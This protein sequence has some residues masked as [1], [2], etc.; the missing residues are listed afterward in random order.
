MPLNLPKLEKKVLSFWKRENIFEKSV[1]KRKGKPDF[2]FYEGPPTANAP[3]GLHHVLA[4]VFKDIIC[5]FQTMKG[6]R[7][8]RKAGWDTHGLPVE[9]QIEKKLGFKNKRDI[10]SFGVSKFNRLCKKSV[11]SYKKTWEKLTE[12]IGYWLD[13]KNPYITYD[14]NYIETLWWILKWAF[15]KKLLYE[16]YKVVP[17][18]PRCGTPLSSHE[19]AQGYKRVKEPAVYLK[20][21]VVTPGFEKTFL[22]V[23]TTT[24]WTL[25][26]NVAIALNPQFTYLLFENS[27]G[28]KLIF[29]KERLKAL[30][31]EGKVIK[32]FQG[33][34]LTGL[35]YQ[36]FYPPGQF[37]ENMFLTRGADFVSL[38][39]GTGLVHIAPAFGQEDMELIKKENEELEKLGKK[40]I[41]ILI[42]VEPDGKFSLNVK[43]WA[44][45]FF[46]KADPLIIN[47]LKERG[48]LF[49][50]EM[51]EHEYPFCWRCHTPLMYYARKSWFLKMR[52]LQKELVRNNE[53]IN[54]VPSYLK[55]GRFGEWI[56]GVK[57]W[58]LSRERY[59]GT[60]LP[61]WVCKSCGYKKAIGSK[62]EL[63]KGQKS[64]NQYWVLRHGYSQRQLTNVSDC[65]PEK[66]KMHLTEKGKRTVSRVAKKLKK[67][68]I[69]IIF[70]SDLLRAK[71]TA[72]II[73]RETGAKIVYDKRLR[74]Y[75]VGIFNGKSTI[76][77]WRWLEKQK[78]FLKTKLPEGESL[79]DIRRRTYKL[80]LHLEKKYQGK[81]ILLVSHE[82]PITVLEETLKGVPLY[83]LLKERRANR[84][85][86]IKPGQLRKIEFK[87]LPFNR[88]M[89]LDFHKPLIDKVKFVCPKCGGVMERV[90]EVID[91]WFDSGAMPF[92]QYHWPFESRRRKK[93]KLMPPKLFPADYISEAIDQTRGWFYTLLAVSTLLGFGPS[94]KNVLSLG[95]ILD[96]KGEKMS[97]SKGNIVDPWEMIGKYGVDS[98]R[99]YFY[100]M[101]S[102][103]EPKLF[104][105]KGVFDVL[106]RFISIFWN[107]SLFF[108]T[109]GLKLHS[110]KLGRK[111]I[112]ILDKWILS[113]MEGLIKEVG[114]DLQKYDITSAARKIENFTISDL[115][116][117]YIRRSR[118][119]FQSPK[120]RKDL[121]IASRVLSFVLL[122]L[123]KISAPFIPFLSETIYQKLTGNAF[124]KEKSVHLEN[125]P[126]YEKRLVDKK[127]EKE[128]E[129]V[130]EIVS[131]ALRKRAEAKI[132]VRQPL[133]SLTIKDNVL[134]QKKELLE[135]IKGEVN[136]KEII[137][138]KKF[139]LDTRITPQLKEEG[140]LREVLRAIQLMRK[141]KK[142]KPNHKI[143]LFIASSPNLSQFLEKNKDFLLKETIARELY[144]IQEAN[145]P[146]FRKEL[147]IDGEK[148]YLALKKN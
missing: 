96:E 39:E 32:E 47:D 68:G 121:E 132:K 113:K 18:C 21:P 59:W 118:R 144:F 50:E 7:V 31:L 140:I 5:R 42:P 81:K 105:E 53:K 49:K 67:E 24:P 44:G 11:W 36:P 138:G 19:V 88:N 48:L 91:C 63:L 55:E 57:D 10:E 20:F 35:R 41:P 143:N 133:P 103:A 114:D 38:E 69:D 130:R 99:W 15:E 135:L 2:V 76:S 56:R 52:E 27:N 146:P 16:D 145:L 141:E 147:K 122:N 78:D 9:L 136:V 17:Y 101:S 37:S 117:W 111:R 58:S 40:P 3:P 115:S 119:R 90:P 127:L 74:E 14:P 129:K 54:W 128:M 22:L 6:F 120:S 83:N 102:P 4:R 106:R 148:I 43:K 98:I 73:S 71:E 51:Y 109:Y 80:L 75:N 112:T 94:Y 87:I 110:Y 86:L 28:E 79:L 89:E 34:D 25:P 131:R 65:W 116:L 124:Q 13:M 84:T 82:L 107:S 72:E 60:P 1:S 12:R 104:S 142:L 123:S 46:K 85:R 95:H 139:A 29:A 100:T 108:D 70:S 93:G 97:K 64:N 125:W 66:K 62:E 33:K 26:G 137:L 30:K 92:A 8:L 134:W 126:S 77:S 45:L 23:W 61:V